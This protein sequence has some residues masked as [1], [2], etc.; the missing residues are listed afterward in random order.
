MNIFMPTCEWREVEL[1]SY[2]YSSWVKQS[3]NKDIFWF[4]MRLPACAFERSRC[5]RCLPIE[6]LCWEGLAAPWSLHETRLKLWKKK[7][8]VKKTPDVRRV[9]AETFYMF[10]HHHHTFNWASS[11]S[12]WLLTNIFILCR[13]SSWVILSMSSTPLLFITGKDSKYTFTETD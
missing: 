4:G 6:R 11:A 8:R 13:S 5:S 1:T 9:W 7:K 12:S 3:L 10:L 2:P